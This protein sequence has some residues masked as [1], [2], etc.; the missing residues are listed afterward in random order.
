MLSYQYSLSLR[1]DLFKKQS[2]IKNSNKEREF[3]NELR[4]RI[5]SMK[6]T[7]ITS[8]EMFEHITYLLLL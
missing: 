1:K 5:G 6:I 2:I 8:Y 3:I 7:N 4:N